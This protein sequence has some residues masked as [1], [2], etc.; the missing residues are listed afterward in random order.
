MNN[1]LALTSLYAIAG[2]GLWVWGSTLAVHRFD[3]SRP[4][5]AAISWIARM[6]PRDSVSNRAT[7]IGALIVGA[8]GPIALAIRLR[9]VL[10]DATPDSVDVLVLGASIA[11]ALIW[12]AILLVMLTRK[13]SA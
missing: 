2:L 1:Q 5:P 6:G 11:A 12:A 7:A 10:R 8:L 9:Q 13:S 3:P 4:L